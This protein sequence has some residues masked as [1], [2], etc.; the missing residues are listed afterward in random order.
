MNKVT[1]LHIYIYVYIY[2][3]ACL[4]LKFAKKKHLPVLL[5]VASSSCGNGHVTAVTQCQIAREKD[6]SLGKELEV[7]TRRKSEDKHYDTVDGRNPVNQLR[8]R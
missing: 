7:R 3:Y 1:Y 5:L 2:I 6:G 4:V 8:E